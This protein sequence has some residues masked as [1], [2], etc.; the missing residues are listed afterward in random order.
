VLQARGAPDPRVQQML[1]RNEAAWASTPSG[2]RYEEMKPP[3]AGSARPEPVAAATACRPVPDRPFGDERRQAIC[4]ATADTIVARG[5]DPRDSRGP[6]SH[7][8]TR[9]TWHT[10]SRQ[11]ATPQGPDTPGSRRRPSCAPW[12][13]AHGSV[14]GQD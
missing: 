9:S 1:A 11:A 5:L 7:S 12:P 6:A 14:G 4:G 10:P 8:V 3:V 13:L 2:T